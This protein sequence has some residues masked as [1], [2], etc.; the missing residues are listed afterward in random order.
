[1][2]DFFQRRSERHLKVQLLCFTDEGWRDFTWKDNNRVEEGL[3]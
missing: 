3:L 1:M 2:I